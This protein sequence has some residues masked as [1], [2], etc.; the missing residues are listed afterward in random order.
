MLGLWR[1]TTNYGG[2][3]RTSNRS[4]ENTTEGKGSGSGKRR[5]I[6][7]GG[8]TLRPCTCSAPCSPTCSRWHISQ[9]SAKRNTNDDSE[10][11]KRKLFRISKG[12]LI[13]VGVFGFV[14]WNN[15]P[16]GV[17]QTVTNTVAS[18]SPRTASAAGDAGA[19]PPPQPPKDWYPRSGGAANGY[20]LPRD[21]SVNNPPWQ[22][23]KRAP[24]APSDGARLEAWSCKIAGGI[25]GHEVTLESTLDNR[26][27]EPIG[28]LQVGR[29][30][31][32]QIIEQ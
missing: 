12:K 17:K 28:T 13:A 23:W 10:Q 26:L 1:L 3:R 7:G 18:S 32:L 9:D 2:T 20:A 30:G 15:L 21:F 31:G 8:T 29:D 27:A 4:A 11:P 16:D 24:D 14:V 19:P 6:T 25:P 22:V 5:S